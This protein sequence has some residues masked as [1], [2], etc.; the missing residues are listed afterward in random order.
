MDIV[1]RLER[2]ESDLNSGGASK[3]RKCSKELQQLHEQALT[4]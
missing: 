3:E 4:N 2:L 1:L